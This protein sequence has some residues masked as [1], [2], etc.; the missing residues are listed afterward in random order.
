LEDS[1][2]VAYFFFDDKD[3]RPKDVPVMLAN[4]LGQ[5][6]KQDSELIKHLTQE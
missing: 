1:Y 4:V 2:L 3:E 6:L 5:L